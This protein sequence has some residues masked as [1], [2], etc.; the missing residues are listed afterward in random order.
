MAK[1]SY[2]ESTLYLFLL[3]IGQAE[4]VNDLYE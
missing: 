4:R 1:Q 2:T 3:L